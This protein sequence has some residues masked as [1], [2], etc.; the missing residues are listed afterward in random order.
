MII[1]T[2]TETK[3]KEEE[4]QEKLLNKLELKIFLMVPRILLNH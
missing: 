2:K 3:R 4:E 1:T